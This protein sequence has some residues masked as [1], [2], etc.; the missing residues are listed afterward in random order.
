MQAIISLLHHSIL[1][2]HY[3]AF[4]FHN[5]ELGLANTFG[6]VSARVGDP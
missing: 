3:I 6:P 1:K 4:L 5:K 2:P